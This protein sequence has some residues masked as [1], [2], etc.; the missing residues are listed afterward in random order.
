[1]DNAIKR[2]IRARNIIFFTLITV[3]VVTVIIKSGYF[4]PQLFRQIQTG[5]FLISFAIFGLFWCIEAY[6]LKLA[7]EF[8]R[9][10]L[11]LPKYFK[12]VFIGQLFNGITPFASGGQ[13]AQIYH[14][15]KSGIPGGEGASALFI[16]FLVYQSSLTIYGI[17]FLL[18][19][20]SFFQAILNEYLYLI[21]LGFSINT[22]VV[23]FLIALFFWK[24][25]IKKMLFQLIRITP[26]IREDAKGKL[27]KKFI[28]FM[29][30][31]SESVDLLK[32]RKGVFTKLFTLNLVKLTS[33][34]SI[35]FFIAKSL[36]VHNLDI[37]NVIAASAF[38]MMI[39]SFVPV[40]GAVGGA[41]GGFYFIFSPFFTGERAVAI[42]VLWRFMTYY[43]A[44]LIGVFLFVWFLL[45]IHKASAAIREV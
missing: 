8:G 5:W 41:E 7:I 14:L 2:L 34:H 9:P 6:M 20:F 13:A 1:L 17:F 25:S 39:T 38:L 10:R 23:I 22:G 30:D 12:N 15:H 35:P 19:K 32:R 42:M 29:K 28:A 3:I 45:N 31:F 37:V 18:S 11:G 44:M 16:N 36:G 43:L 4:N 26:F 21:F 27:S 33:L 40:P 24:S